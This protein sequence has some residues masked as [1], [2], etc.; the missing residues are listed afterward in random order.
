MLER[1]PQDLGEREDEMP[2]GDGADHLL[3]DEF[4]PQGAAF[5]GAGRAEPSLFAG[6]GDEVFV[7]T[8]VASDARETA[9]GKA[10][11]ETWERVT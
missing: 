11:P 7:P 5:S 4:R 1:R 2:V 8:G 6:E 9:L 10:A 3:P